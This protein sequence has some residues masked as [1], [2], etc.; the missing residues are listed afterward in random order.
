[1]KTLFIYILSTV[2]SLIIMISIPS[3]FGVFIWKTWSYQS[4]N[5]EGY[6]LALISFFM[7]SILWII[8]FGCIFLIFLFLSYDKYY[9][10]KI[11]KKRIFIN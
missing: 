6:S 7:G 2:I 4:L 8:F 11:E 5:S 3:L 10:T 9:A 1:M